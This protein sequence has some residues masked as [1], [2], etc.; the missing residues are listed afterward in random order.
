[1]SPLWND[2]DAVIDGLVA[3]ALEEDVGPGDWTTRWTVPAGASARAVIVAKQPLVVSGTE[4]A[5]RVF[6]A[7]DPGLE[8]AVV[9]ADGEAVEAGEAV[10]DLVGSARGVLVAERAALNFLGRLSGIAT[11]TRA[12][13]LAVEG[14]RARIL[15]TRKTTPGWRLLEKAAVAH[16]GGA[17]HRIGLH[18]MVLIKDNHIAAAGGITPAVEGVRKHNT[19]GLAVELE[20]SDLNQLREALALD[21][22]RLLLDNMDLETLGRAVTIARNSS[23]R[24]PEL[25]ASGNVTLETV[26]RIAETGVDF[27]SVGALTHSAPAAD[28]SLRVLEGVIAPGGQPMTDGDGHR[29]D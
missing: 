12:F 20:V 2:L 18:D 1:M 15:D 4:P 8:V 19:E 5:R 7:V 9:R 13:V 6:A 17:N 21:V 23:G 25:E 24:I 28:L 3:S 14:T 11:L 27:I 10:L 29:A 22:E 26:G 16:G